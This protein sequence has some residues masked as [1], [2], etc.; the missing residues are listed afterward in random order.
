MSFTCWFCG[1]ER[2][3]EERVNGDDECVH[4][5]LNRTNR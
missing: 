4:C 5:W 3:E 1:N 2:D